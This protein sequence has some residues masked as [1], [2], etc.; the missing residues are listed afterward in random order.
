MEKIYQKN[1]HKIKSLIIP[2]LIGIAIFSRFFYLDKT[3]FFINDQGRDLM[4]LLK[5]VINKK[6]ILIGPPTSFFSNIGG[7]YF[8]P[9]Y[10]YFLLPFFLISR[11]PLFITAIIPA[12]F[13]INLILIFKIK[14]LEFLEKII[15]SLLIIGSSYSLYYTRFLWN[16]NLAFLLSF[17]LNILFLLYRKKIN[18]SIILASLFGLISGSVFQMHYGMFFFYVGIMVLLFPH[19]KSLFIYL[20][21]FALSFIPLLVFNLRHNYII[22]RAI[23]SGISIFSQKSNLNILSFLTIF[24]KI[25]GFYII[26]GSVVPG[27]VD[28]IFGLIS[29]IGVWILL[30]KN[31]TYLNRLLIIIYPIFLI[32]LIIFKRNF[33]YY[34]ACFLW[35]YYLGLAIVLS[36]LI[37]KKGLISR[38]TI[39][40]LSIIIIV[41]VKDY[42]QAIN[43][44]YSINTQEIIAKVVA[45]KAK[46]LKIN[47]INL[48]LRPN[49]LDKRGVE[50][51]L[52]AKY[53]YQMTTARQNYEYF[54]CYYDK[55][56]QGGKKTNILYQQPNLHVYFL[57]NTIKSK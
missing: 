44:L 47:L 7:I 10:Y 26:P 16:L 9:H 23:I 12:L 21:G 48:D 8:G 31:K 55:C 4:E 13:V 5:M 41:N 24:G 45:A 51:I 52:L 46:D 20:I 43:S 50:Y 1:K 57:D 25:F 53:G 49:V 56:L 27:Y 3:A 30:L 11:D 42:I 28:I 38:L 6:P 22:F 34:L 37:K 17:L 39:I 18:T 54:V 35:W 14:E 36:Q 32:S 15:F 33:D 2:L 19:K 40:C 29:F